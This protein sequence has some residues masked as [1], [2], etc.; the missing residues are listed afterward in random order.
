MQ[1][2][3]NI[4]VEFHG[5]QYSILEVQNAIEAAKVGIKNARDM[6]LLS[7][8]PEGYSKD[9][10]KFEFKIESLLKIIPK[11]EN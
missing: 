4:T 11:F 6:I 10:T 5:Q 2:Q 3:N 7:N 1:E 8:Y 9:I